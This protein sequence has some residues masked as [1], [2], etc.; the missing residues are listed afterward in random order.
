MIGPHLIRGRRMR[1][2]D[3]RRAPR[4]VLFEGEIAQF[5]V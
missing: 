1:E 2:I 5:L 4:A 3:Y